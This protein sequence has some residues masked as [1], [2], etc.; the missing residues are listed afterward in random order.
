MRRFLATKEMSTGDF[1][2]EL[3]VNGNTFYK[4]M[5][6]RY[7]D[8]KWGAAAG[9]AYWAAMA[10]FNR[11]AAAKKAA[12]GKG[13][14]K[15]K[16][17][18]KRGADDGGAKAAEKAAKEERAAKR[19][20]GTLLLAKI[21][22]V[23]L[24]DDA[25]DEDG[26]AYVYDNCDVVRRKCSRFLAS[27]LTTKTAWLKAMGVNPN[28]FNGFMN[29]NGKGAG[30]GNCSYVR[31]FVFFEKLRVLEKKPKSKLRVTNEARWPTGYPLRHDNGKRWCVAGERP[32]K[33][34]FDIDACQDRRNAFARASARSSATALR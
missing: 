23:E 1:I 9:G 12:K 3:G 2:A 13:K 34:I 18:R 19:R 14:G 7:K 26:N 15:G 28:S 27:G 4:F 16:G 11:Q 17:K 33:S 5:N 31:A 8:K 10:Y 6:N 20:E 21:E 29:F 30:A 25:A 24:D 32:D 22:E